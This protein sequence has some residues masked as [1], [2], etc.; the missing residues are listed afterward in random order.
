MVRVY[1]NQVI[2]TI[3]KQTMSQLL[4]QPESI[5]N[6]HLFHKNIGIQPTIIYCNLSREHF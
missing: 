5:L 2:L 4:L 6:C 1:L 3:L